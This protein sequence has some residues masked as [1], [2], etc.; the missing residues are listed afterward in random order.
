MSAT[1]Y[2]SG[3]GGDSGHQ[4]KE[5]IFKS[6]NFVIL[7]G[8]LYWLLAKKLKEFFVGRRDAIKA[9]LEEAVASR[10]EAKRKFEEY[11]A[12][13]QKATDEIGGIAETIKAQG[14]AEKEKIIE[15]A[16]KAAG[17]MKEDAQARMEQEFQKASD[18]LRAEAAMLSVQMAE[19]ILKKNVTRDDHNSMVVDYLDKVVSKH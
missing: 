3:G 1:V 4:M 2:A 6:I 19:E 12:K 13:L 9:E 16:Q 5:F 10:E 8:F 14:Q 17:K 7:I 18:Q 15:D 11:D